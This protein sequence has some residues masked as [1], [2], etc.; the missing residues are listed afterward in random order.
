LTEK[1]L[2]IMV[3][4]IFWSEKQWNW[5]FNTIFHLVVSSLAWIMA[6]S[7]SSNTSIGE[8]QP[9]MKVMAIDG[10]SSLLFAL[11]IRHTHPL[12][13]LFDAINWADIDKRCVAVY[14]NNK[15]G[16]PAYPPQV[17]FRILLLMYYSGTPFESATLLRLETDV[18]WRW[19]SGLS[20]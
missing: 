19:F 10:I 2:T 11:L 6:P 18:A 16:A 5:L 3:P 7:T 14:K 12:R 8:G 4:R 13:K 1:E 9:R 17:L 20:P 15:R